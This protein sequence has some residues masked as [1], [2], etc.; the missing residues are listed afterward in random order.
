MDN[1]DPTRVEYSS[2]GYTYV[3][4]LAPSRVSMRCGLR[5]AATLAPVMQG[6]T[7][8]KSKDGLFT[9][10]MIYL[11]TN[12]DLEDK[13]IS[14]VDAFAPCTEVFVDGTNPPQSY[15]LGSA[16]A[17]GPW[18]DVHFAGKQDEFIDWLGRACH[19]NL[20]SFLG[21]LLAKAKAAESALEELMK[22]SESPTAAPKSG[23]SGG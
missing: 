4:K 5:V 10:A 21:G 13:V 20:A 19:Q 17:K 14:L 9:A 18:V 22:N 15:N 11:F 23:S 16:G 1:S 6:I 12:P 7:R 2:G 8:A 3:L